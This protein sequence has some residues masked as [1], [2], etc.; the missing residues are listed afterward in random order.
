MHGT[1]AQRIGAVPSVIAR[2][3]VGRLLGRGRAGDLREIVRGW[4]SAAK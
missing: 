3:A 4:L 1:R 2:R